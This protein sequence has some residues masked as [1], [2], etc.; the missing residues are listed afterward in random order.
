VKPHGKKLENIEISLKKKIDFVK[1]FNPLSCYYS[2]EEEEEV[3][4]TQ[5]S[6]KSEENDIKDKSFFRSNDALKKIQKYKSYL[7][8]IDITLCLVLILGVVLSHIENEIF[9]EH[10]KDTRVNAILAMN[11]LKDFNSSDNYSSLY[12]S[13]DFQTFLI[14][15]N[16]SRNYFENIHNFDDISINLEVPSACNVIRSLIL[17]S[18]CAARMDY[19][20]IL[21]GL[22]ILSKFI[23]YTIEYNFKSAKKFS[24]NPFNQSLST[25]QV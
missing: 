20:F 12:H 4:N 10:N 15:T 21:V 19:L 23:E 8:I 13:S 16:V 25:R 17:I 18:S 1:K 5:N 6:K 14:S 2:S 24:M 11:Y 22:N 7:K 3:N 9:Y